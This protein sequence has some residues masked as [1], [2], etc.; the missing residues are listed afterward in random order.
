MPVKYHATGNPLDLTTEPT[1]PKPIG[2]TD[3]A[4][5]GALTLH[6]RRL[7]D[8]LLAVA[9]D[10]IDQDCEHH[11]RMSDLRRL[12]QGEEA[13]MPTNTNARIKASVKRIKSL[14][15]EFN[16]LGEAEGDWAIE[17]LLGSVRYAAAKDT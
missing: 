8:T 15:V 16:Y 11:V 2:L 3:L 4:N 17:N 7:F 14:V 9:Y 13:A 5:A 6:D 1:F 12:A 10:K